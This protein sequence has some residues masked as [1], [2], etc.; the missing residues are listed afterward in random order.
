MSEWINTRP[1]DDPK[2]KDLIWVS[3]C[4]AHQ[5]YSTSCNN[6]QAG[7]W[8]TREE[9]EWKHPETKICNKCKMEYYNSNFCVCCSSRDFHFMFPDATNS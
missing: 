1:T 5:N 6:C 7:K 2:L 4:S 9:L 3:F 8:F